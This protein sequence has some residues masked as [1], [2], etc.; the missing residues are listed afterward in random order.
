MLSIRSMLLFNIFSLLLIIIHVKAEIMN[1]TLDDFLED[2]PGIQTLVNVGIGCA[3]A[4]YP[5]SQSSITIER[6]DAQFLT[7]EFSQ[8]NLPPED[9]VV[10]H[11]ANSNEADQIIYGRDHHGPGNAAVAAS[12]FSDLFDTTTLTLTLV[13]VQSPG[14]S[15]PFSNCAG[16]RLATVH[17]AARGA[18]HPSSTYETICGVDNS[19]ESAC[20]KYL[21]DVTSVADRIIRLT[22][23]KASGT[24]YC[25]GWLVGCEGH[26][27]T[28]EH[29]IGTQADAENVKFEFM[30]QG[31]LCSDDCAR[32][33]ACPGV[34][35][36][37]S[38]QLVAVDAALDYALLKLN[39]NVDVNALYGYLQMRESGP[40]MN[41]RLY[42]AQHPAGKG[43][44][45]ARV[46][47]GSYARIVSLTRSGCAPNQAAYYA[48]TEGT[49][50]CAYTISAPILISFIHRRIIWLTCD[51]GFR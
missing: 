34:I 29:C 6:A 46:N 12:F 35:H 2:I 39:T 5:S 16:F 8:F 22:I 13:S 42:I 45:I 41:E 7:V 38:A 47:E 17:Y 1:T 11:S 10:L 43:K 28:N 9:Y 4:P 27:M 25:T 31:E 30:A 20:Y 26:V 18:T 37:R 32:G 19:R 24:F 48:D 23:S 44:R 33:G 49:N 50:I 51:R 36:A 3:G 15:S 14:S 40:V 21:N